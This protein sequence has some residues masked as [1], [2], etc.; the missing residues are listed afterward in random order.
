MPLYAYRALDA[1][2]KPAKGTLSAASEREVLSV[3]RERSFFPLRVKPVRSIGDTIRSQLRIGQGKSL[4]SRELGAFLRQLA[5]LIQATLP[6]DAALRLILDQTSNPSLQ[7]ALGEVQA[8]VVEGSFLS[9]AMA[10]HP[11][12]FPPMVVNM[13]RTG[14][15]SGALGLVLERLALYYENMSK[16]RNR[17]AAA[18]VYPIFMLVF[19]MGVVVF[20]FIQIIP[21]ITAIY[22]N[23][24]KTLPWSTRFMIGVSDVLVGYWWACLLLA[25]GAFYGLMW[26]SRTEQGRHLKDRMELAVPV[27]RIFRQ[28]V[29]LQRFTETLATMLKSGVE[30]NHALAVSSEVVENR[31]YQNGLRDVIFD[32]QNK[33]MQFSMALRRTG[34]FPEEICQMIA[35]GEETATLDAMLINM[36]E[37][38]SVEVG[39]A[40]DSALALLEPLM[41]LLLGIIIGFIVISVLLPILNQ[42]QLLG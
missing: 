8:R 39:A 6:Y 19:S 1:A 5:T 33:G 24:N 3:L 36:S 2:G 40:M 28:K 15:T 34:L 26:M 21:K 20:L 42:N 30:L 27:W 7:S 37:R 31:I 35:I 10:P 4:S 38:L 29:L 12:I 16:I 14:E 11:R 32:I 23:F 13:V 25:C 41:I 17:I 18:L 9:D 22:E